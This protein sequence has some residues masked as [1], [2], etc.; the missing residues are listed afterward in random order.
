MFLCKKFS[1]C[2]FRGAVRKYWKLKISNSLKLSI[3]ALSRPPNLRVAYNEII[4]EVQGGE[5]AGQSA[6]YG[7]WNNPLPEA[8]TQEK[9]KKGEINLPIFSSPKMNPSFFKTEG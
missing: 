3:F 1:S 5:A 2:H 4:S 7:P 9:K 8:R 6:A